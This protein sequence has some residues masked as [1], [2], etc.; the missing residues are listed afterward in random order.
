M[1]LH[2]IIR[3]VITTVN[4]DTLA[5]VRMSA[6]AAI[7]ADGTQIPAYAN[8]IPARIQVQALSAGEIRQTDNLNLQGLMRGIYLYG[9][10]EGLVRKQGKGGD[11]IIFGGQVWLIVQVLETWPG[12]CKVAVSLQMDAS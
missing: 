1:N 10:W 12:W 2:G 8:D 3:G 4:P 5:I 6:G 7:S 11:L 9:D